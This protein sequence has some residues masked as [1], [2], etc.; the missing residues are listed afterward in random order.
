MFRVL[1]RVLAIVAVMASAVNAQCALSCSLQASQLARPGAAVASFA[2]A[3]HACCP[4][5][6]SPARNEVPRQN[7]PCPTPAPAL[8][9]VKPVDA[10]QFA[11]NLHFIDLTVSCSLVRGLQVQRGALPI[12]VELSDSYGIPAFSILRV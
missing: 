11:D 10:F 9:E 6:K 1:G 8:F 2:H 12:S 3:G 7:R 5:S 4:D